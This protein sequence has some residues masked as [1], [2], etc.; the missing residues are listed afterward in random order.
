M[1]DEAGSKKPSIPAW[2]TKAPE[3]TSQSSSKTTNQAERETP[4]Q[5]RTAL[6]EQAKTFLQEFSVRDAPREKKVAFLEKKGLQG[7]EIQKLLDT[8]SSKPASFNVQDSGIKTIH[9]SSPVS[10]STIPDTTQ[11]STSASTSKPKPSSQ[12]THDIPPI[13]TYPEFLLHPTKPPPLITIQRLTYALYT[14][15]GISALTYGASKHLVQP[16][17]QSL[18]SARH[19]LSNTALHNLEKLNEKLEGSVSH[20]PSLSNSILLKQGGRD[21]HLDNDDDGSDVESVD[22]D[23][24]ELFHR[25]IATQTS[26]QPTPR[27]SSSSSSSYSLSTSSP[28]HHSPPQTDAI[29]TQSARLTTLTHSLSSLLATDSPSSSSSSNPL[30]ESIS[31]CQS[32]LDKLAFSMNSYN[33]YNLLY[34]SPNTNTNTTT[35]KGNKDGRT[36]RSEIEEEDEAIKFRQEIR[37]V[38]GALLSVRSFPVGRSAVTAS[39]AGMAT[40]GM[41]TVTGLR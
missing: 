14:L 30:L 12:P 33:D 20:I 23:P 2:Q 29:T 19:D 5:E 8:A 35:N 25:D 7:D 17:L 31:T 40:A 9:D 26:P 1:A 27:P 37:A 10:T 18:T 28:S 6:I 24:T 38:K 22:S 15:A 36:K 4:A 39:T 11:S 21:R 16:M 3:E 13:I 34:G 32:Y 41:S